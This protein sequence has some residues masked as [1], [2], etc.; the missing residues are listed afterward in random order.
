MNVL[1]PDKISTIHT[2]IKNGVSQ[3]EIRKK[4][5]IDRKTIRKYIHGDIDPKSPT[6]DKVATGSDPPTESK[7]ACEPYREWI[8]EQVRLG[9]NS[10]AIYQ[11]LVERHT[12][13]HK[14]N[15]V[16]RFVR[17]LKKTDPKQFD[18]LE[19]PPGEEAQV[20]YGQGAL[21]NDGSG[22]YRRPR[23]F[24]MTLKYSGRSFRK[25]VWKSGKEVWAKLH[26]EAFR[27]FGGCPQ[28]VVLDN[29]K[30]G[31]L[32]PDIYE[33]EMNP[34][35]ESMLKHYGVISDTAR[36][37]DPNRKGSVESAVKHTQNTALK[38]RKFET[39]EKQ[40]EWLMHWEE[41]WAAQRIHGRAKRQVEEMYQEE[42][43]F[44]QRVPLTSFQYF[45]QETRTVWDD[46]T[47]QIGQSYYSALPAPLY[48][49]VIVRIYN[50]EIEI[51]D[52]Q[53]MTVIRR[54]IK[55]S[56]PGSVRMEEADRIFNP[57][58]QTGY[59]LAKAENIGPKT[60]AL[61]ELMF[62]EQGR[63]GQRRMQ[64]IVNLARKYKAC[65]IELAAQKALDSGLH[66]YQAIKRL[67]Q[68]IAEKEEIPEQGDDSLIQSHTL[69]RPP[70]DYASFFDQYAAGSKPEESVPSNR[71]R[72]Y[73]MS[74]D[75]MRDIWKAASWEKVIDAFGLTPIRQSKPNEIWIKSP[76]TDEK[77][78][79]L[80]LN[81][82]RNIFNDFS[83]G[84]GKGAGILNFCQ[85]MLKRQGRNMNCYE[86]AGWMVA[87]GISSPSEDI[88][89]R[90]EKGEKKS[91]GMNPPISVD[92][93]RWL[94]LTHPELTRRGVSQATC[95][96]LGCGYL[97]I[98]N[99]S[100]SPLNKR[101]VFQIRGIKSENHTIRSVIL[102]HTGRALTPQQEACDGKYWSY[103]FKKHLEIYNQDKLLT[104]PE[105]ITQ[106]KKFGLVLVEGFFDVA[107]L[108]EAGI[109]NVGALMGARI[110]AS[111]IERLQ[112]IHSHSGF[113]KVTLLLDRDEAG[114][115]GALDMRSM[116]NR[117]GF[118]V[119]IFDWETTSFR[120]SN[121]IKDPGDMTIKQLQ[122]LR[123]QNKI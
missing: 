83:S 102:S 25:T 24:V 72:G 32:K 108:I 117:N 109:L 41:R 16:K 52:P 111:Q 104:D 93:R 95:R 76:F 116:L 10:V 67:V 107:A 54:H 43:P 28:Y 120:I 101:L 115:K 36:V 14:Y 63:P 51:I 45:K 55:S 84:M 49:K 42:K 78:A 3:R 9:R 69:I 99:R 22:K 68:G 57:S 119:N 39:I 82:D 13:A 79:S 98:Q 87:Q 11:D 37:R 1:K 15:S 94:S 110:S 58:R 46:G 30:E 121:D 48:Q 86:V 75:Q 19:F 114:V 77:T 59:L 53:T 33:P 105:A 62:K 5:G 74:R 7:S 70:E 40:N 96:Y 20:D 17:G 8:E 4:T 66:N 60:K 80:H 81:L 31:V 88:K 23:L 44:L 92:L 61:C 123:R 91:V 2:L 47:I 103:P 97:P 112:L 26:E 71:N 65:Y 106:M 85:E 38:G 21:T 27:Y 73:V 118:C 89:K 6:S 34:V 56:R 100:H 50:F 122:W 113:T 29:L 64:G 12:F 90:D 18:R 35:Y